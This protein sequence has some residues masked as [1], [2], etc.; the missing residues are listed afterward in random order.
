M[1]FPTL[2]ITW[3]ICLMV[4]VFI[5]LLQGE[6]VLVTKNVTPVYF[7]TLTTTAFVI[8]HYS[9]PSAVKKI[10]RICT[11]WKLLHEKLE[12]GPPCPWCNTDTVVDRL[13]PAVR[14]FCV[15]CIERVSPHTRS[16]TR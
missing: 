9:G 2:L 6:S 4:M 12:V 3:L 14:Y 13:Q 10:D 1:V 15:R 5:E 7:L 16:K 11:R 8:Y